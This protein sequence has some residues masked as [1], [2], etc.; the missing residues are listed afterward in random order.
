M[1]WILDEEFIKDKGDIPDR[2]KSISKGTKWVIEHGG[3]KDTVKS[4]LSREHMGDIGK[5]DIWTQ[6]KEP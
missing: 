4:R 6:V 3:P 2:V 1:N 5:A